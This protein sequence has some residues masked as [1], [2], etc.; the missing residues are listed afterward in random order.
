MDLVVNFLKE[1]W[2]AIILL[3][4]SIASFIVSICRKKASMSVTDAIKAS[5]VDEIPSLIKIAELSE[6][7]GSHKLDL[8]VSAGL[9]KIKKLL[10]VSLSITECEYWTSYIK[11]KVEL[12]LSTPTKKC[13][14]KKCLVKKE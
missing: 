1:N 6:L 14:V 2:Y 8:V 13:E 12:I 9:E 3:S 11:E 5:L 7:D 10:G 4:F